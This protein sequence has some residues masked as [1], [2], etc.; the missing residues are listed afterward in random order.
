MMKKK[1]LIRF[2]DM[3]LKGKNIGFFIKR[4]RK[5]LVEKLK[6]LEVSYQ[7]THDRIYVDYQVHDETDIINRL[8]QIPGIFSYSVVYVSSPTIEDMIKTAVHVLN[9]EATKP[10]MHIKI[11]TKRADK[12]FPMTSQDITLK[13]ASPIFQQA[14]LKYTIDVKHPEETLRIELRRDYAYVYLRNHKGLGGFPY[15]TQGKGLL[16]LSGG[17]DSPV[18]GFLAMKQGIEVDLIHFDSSP[19][20]PLESTQKVI[21]LAKVLSKY[22]LDGKIKLHLVPFTH[23]HDLILKNVFDPYIITVMR[24][25]MYRIAEKFAIRHKHLCLI[26]GESVGQVASQTLPSM[27]VVEAVTKLPILRP[28]ITYDKLDIIKISENIES[29]PISIQPFNDCCSIYVPKSPVTKPMEVYAKK[30]ES[31]FEFEDIIYQLVRNSYTLEISNETNIQLSTLGFT[32]E[33]AMLA[34]QKECESI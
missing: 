30:Y 9:V 20:T 24:R 27:Q 29:Y 17:I 15:G 6:G 32:L 19:L 3:M 13:I 1:I 12:D 26:N 2:G 5:H 18:A 7:F 22:T 21:D 31:T 28:L 8:S 11:E 16:M 4:V 14:N 23:L 33:E 10:M 25:M 34:Y